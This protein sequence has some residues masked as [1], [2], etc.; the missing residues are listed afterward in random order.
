M[1]EK[2]LAASITA[3]SDKA[4]V[5]SARIAISRRNRVASRSVSE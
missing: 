2:A 3:A 1:I 5:S 4:T